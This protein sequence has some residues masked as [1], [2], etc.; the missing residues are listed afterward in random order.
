MPA[1]MRQ[2]DSGLG[3]LDEPFLKP[4]D[5]PRSLIL[6]MIYRMSRKQFGKVMM[7]LRVFM[8]RM[9]LGFGKFYGN[10]GGL[11]KKLTLPRE[12]VLLIREQVAHINVCTFCIDIAR[13]FTIQSSMSQAK[14]DALSEYR[15]SPLFSDAERAALDYVTE[16]TQNKRVDPE[17]FAR[18]ARH[19]NERQIC[20]IVWLVATEHVYN[21]T[22]IGLNIHSD[23]LCS[24]TK[25]R[26]SP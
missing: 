13:F 22:N 2:S 1:Q 19:Y 24:A 11:D 8:A 14:F 20:E 23:M 15:V 4:I 6:R 9:P 16:L 17:A 10:I 25:Q 5:R 12:T 7:P 21:M 18:L 3:G 26:A